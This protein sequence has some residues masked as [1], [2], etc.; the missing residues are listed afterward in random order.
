MALLRSGKQGQRLTPTAGHAPSELAALPSIRASARD[1]QRQSN[2][3]L[4]IIFSTA[5]LLLAGLTMLGCPGRDAPSMSLQE[6]K[7]LEC[8]GNLRGIAESF[9]TEG[10]LDAN[11]VGFGVGQ[12]TC[13][14]AE[15][16]TYSHSLK[17]AV[18][19]PAEELVMTCSGENH[20]PAG[21]GKD[22]PRWVAGKGLVDFPDGTV[23]R[24]SALELPLPTDAKVIESYAR[25]GTVFA[26][27]STN[28]SLEPWAERYNGL[29]NPG[30]QL[31]NPARKGVQTISG[32][33]NGITHS[34]TLDS[35]R[36]TV[37]I[38]YDP[39]TDAR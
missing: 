2:M 28:E 8:K 19:K 9:P 16:D 26:T 23:A 21:N 27:F 7:A 1:A 38:G 18:G 29:L 6:R 11:Q 25:Q 37:G 15:K 30:S 10:R 22:Y 36:K 13:P 31:V 20:V 32:N 24:P 4:R 33:L 39:I 12:L 34:V 5:S 17:E 35:N 14:A 3:R